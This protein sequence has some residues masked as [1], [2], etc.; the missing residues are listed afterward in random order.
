MMRANIEF[1]QSKTTPGGPIVVNVDSS[2]SGGLGLG[3]GGG[4][5]G[6]GIVGGL[7]FTLWLISNMD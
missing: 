5:G 1:L 4:G 6:F 2:S 3:G 7:L